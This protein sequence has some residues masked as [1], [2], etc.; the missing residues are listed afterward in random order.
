MRVSQRFMKGYTT[1]GVLLREPFFIPKEIQKNFLWNKK[2]CG[3][4]HTAAERSYVYNRIAVLGWH[5]GAAMA[6]MHLCFMQG[7]AL[8]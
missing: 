4:E 1:T 6:L 2:P 8:E 7:M 3:Q 5:T